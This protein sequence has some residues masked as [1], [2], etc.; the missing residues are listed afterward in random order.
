MQIDQNGSISGYSFDKSIIRVDKRLTYTEV[1]EHLAE[2]GKQKNQDIHKYSKMLNDMKELA[3]IL[4]EKR[5]KRGSIE[6][7]FDESKVILDD[8]GNPTD[9]IRKKRNIAESIIEEFMIA[10][11]ET[12]AENFYHANI[13]FIYRIHEAPDKDTLTQLS[14]FL[15]IFGLKLKNINQCKS[16]DINHILEKAKGRSEEKAINLVT[17]RTLKKAIYSEENLG[18]FGLASR[19]YTHFTSPIRRY[20]DLFI[21]RLMSLYLCGEL[22]DKSLDHYSNI[23]SEVAESSSNME[24]RAD[25]AERESLDLKKVEYM[26]RHL[27]DIFIGSISNV[28]SFGFFVEL[29]NTVEGL[30]KV[31]D[32]YDD[33]YIFDEKTYTMTGENS[34]KRFRIGDQVVVRVAA[35]NVDRRQIDF[36]LVY[37]R[38]KNGWQD[39]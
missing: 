31:S 24:V 26:Q 2:P 36:A 16:S 23:I 37:E 35:A 18:H 12:V 15:S 17:L 30:V 21:H 39:V 11:N 38:N 13:P 14:R 29:E 22:K 4:K 19:Y 8:L 6:F 9:I 33:Y 34:G 7:D 32:L 5:K 1:F 27:G 28:M 3:L 20:P 10:A 25:E